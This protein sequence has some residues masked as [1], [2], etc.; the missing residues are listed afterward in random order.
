MFSCL[1]SSTTTQYH[2]RVPIQVGSHVIDQVTNC[3]SNEE[4]QSL[5]QS[6]KVAYVSTIILKAT[7]VGDQEFDLDCV[8]GRVVTSEEVTI[9]TSQTVV[10]KGLT[11]I[12]G[13][14]KPIHVLVESSPK[15][16]SVFILGNTSELKPGKSK[17]EVVI[18]NRS[19]KDVKLKAC[20]EIGTVITD[21]ALYPK[22]II[23]L[24]R[25]IIHITVINNRHI[26]V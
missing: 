25:Y 11:M 15:C 10:V 17:A 23:A 1:I 24:Y 26:T 4:L 2:Q 18:Q 19:E 16:V 9:P 7:S 14:H 6:W 21:T 20:T 12:T 22:V 5:S 13:H 8:R 3:I